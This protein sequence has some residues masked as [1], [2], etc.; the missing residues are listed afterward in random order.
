MNTILGNTPSP[1]ELVCDGAMRSS[2]LGEDKALSQVIR[3]QRLHF[4]LPIFVLARCSSPTGQSRAHL[5][6]CL[7][8]LTRLQIERRGTEL[9]RR[10][11]IFCPT[12][13][14]HEFTIT[15]A[16]LFH[17]SL[18]FLSFFSL[19]SPCLYFFPYCIPRPSPLASSFPR[20]S[21]SS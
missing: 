8:P 13:T 10:V 11:L 21:P 17:H 3:Q 19:L 18:L 9:H 1:F 4:L 7:L 5:A 6:A 15:L 14:I 2:K 20:L 16:F 12:D